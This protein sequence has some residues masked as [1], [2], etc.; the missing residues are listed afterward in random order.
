ML[1]I[2]TPI[3]YIYIY[4]HTHTH[5][6]IYI[7][8]RYTYINIYYLNVNAQRTSY[9]FV[10]RAEVIQAL[11]FRLLS[12]DALRSGWVLDDFPCTK[13][14]AR[15]VVE[16]KPYDEPEKMM[17]SP[18]KTVVYWVYDGKLTS[19]HLHTMIFRK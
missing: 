8:I 16:I 18:R 1:Y 11:R 12:P 5:T 4:I 7:Y 13:A 9:T 17:V 15:D 10:G 2:Y 6:H 3:T 14:Q 19:G